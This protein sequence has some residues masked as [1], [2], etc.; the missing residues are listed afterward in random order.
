MV[1]VKLTAWQEGLQ[2]VSLT[3]IQRSILNLSLKQA[4]KNVDDLLDSTIVNIPHDSLS[5]A[6]LFI[7]EAE[8]IGVICELSSK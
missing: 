7:I 8:K 4:K 5:Q 6:K 2:K 3:K 1:I